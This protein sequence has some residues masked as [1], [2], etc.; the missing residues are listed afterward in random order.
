MFHLKRNVKVCLENVLNEDVDVC[1]DVLVLASNFSFHENEEAVDVL[2][3]FR[4]GKVLPDVHYEGNHKNE[5][6]VVWKNPKNSLDDKDSQEEKEVVPDDVGILNV[7]MVEVQIFENGTRTVSKGKISVELEQLIYIWYIFIYQDTI[8]NCHFQVVYTL[9]EIH[10]FSTV[11]KGTKIN[12][13]YLVNSY[14]VAITALG[15]IFEIFR[16]VEENNG[17][18]KKV[19][20]DNNKEITKI[21]MTKIIIEDVLNILKIKVTKDYRLTF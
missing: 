10:D 13:D 20:L 12:T 6:I 17:P 8:I 2:Y 7:L 11:D 18:D 5:G 14:W 3:L 1:R 16:R 9:I 4:K 15:H 21:N 19:E